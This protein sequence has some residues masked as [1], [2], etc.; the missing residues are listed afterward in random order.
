MQIVRKPAPARNTGRTHQS[1]RKPLSHLPGWEA[2]EA[3]YRDTLSPES[4][5]LLG[6]LPFLLF[7]CF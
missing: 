7:R 6:F 4:R 1:L 3:E 2:A 5:V